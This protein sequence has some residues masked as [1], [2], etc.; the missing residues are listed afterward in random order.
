[1]ILSLL[2]SFSC[3]GKINNH[4]P[5]GWWTPLSRSMKDNCLQFVL[6]VLFPFHFICFPIVQQSPWNENITIFGKVS[7]LH[8][9]KH[10]CHIVLFLLMVIFCVLLRNAVISILS[11][12]KPNNMERKPLASDICL[13]LV[14]SGIFAFHEFV[15]ECLHFWCRYPN[16]FRSWVNQLFSFVSYFLYKLKHT[17]HGP[18]VVHKI[19]N[20]I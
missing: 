17:A 4:R 8:Q 18:N 16:H 5:F 10:E 20:N 9:K 7:N 3:K 11:K 14:T 15:P 12:S 1:M 13:I 6:Y 19:L 2:Q